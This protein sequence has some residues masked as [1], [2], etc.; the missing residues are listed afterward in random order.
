MK[1]ENDLVN[2]IKFIAC[3]FIVILHV[4]DKYDN[5][6]KIIELCR[7]G[8]PFFLMVSGYYAY[9]K[10]KKDNLY[11]SLKQ[12]KKIIKITIIVLICYILF[13]TVN[14]YFINNHDPF[15]WITN[16]LNS[17]TA[18][19]NLIAFNR[20]YYIC[21]IFWYFLA[22]IYVYAIYY[23]IVKL[24]ILKYSYLLIIPLIIMSNA[25]GEFLHL[26]WYYSGNYLF[27]GLPFFLLG[28]YLHTKKLNVNNLLLIGLVILSLFIYVYEVNKF[29]L[30]FL[31]ISAIIIS[32]SLFI[33]A[34]NNDKKLLKNDTSILLKKSS[35]YI[36]Y[37]HCMI[38]D[39]IH[40]LY[41]HYHIELGLYTKIFIVILVSFIYSILYIKL[42]EYVQNKKTSN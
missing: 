3:F 42:K 10:N 37:S 1:K 14:S 35:M 8:V 25:F 5:T 17:K 7:F 24:D 9:K 21:N 22:L 36:F 13:N 31:P 28:N 34:I 2:I 33:L 12:L 41:R 4:M 40:L 32:I 27:T 18:L 29:G 38:R 30:C 26:E 6:N 23:I 11:N 16:H 15:A 20:A 19:L 39:A